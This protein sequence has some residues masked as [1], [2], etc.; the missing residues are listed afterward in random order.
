[1]ARQAG[2]SIATV[3]RVFNGAASVHPETRERI[4]R[5]ATS[6][7]YQPSPLG[8]NLVRGRSF[9]MGLLVPNLSFPLYGTIMHGIEDVLS[10]QGMSALLAS[11]HDDAE[12]ERQ[13]AGS[14]LRHAVDGGIIIN[15]QLGAQLPAQRLPGW[16]HVSPE[17]EEPPLRVELD[18][19]A[20]GAR[21]ATSVRQAARA[22]SARRASPPSC[23]SPGRATAA[24]RATTPR[25]ADSGPPPNCS[26]GRW[27]RC[28]WW[29]T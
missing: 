8:R 21:S 13:A 4:V 3:S 2:V 27:T 7:G 10:A 19:R 9:L 17:T 22:V 20:G 12:G 5:L 16:V 14:I 25:K 15:S 28:S 26:V 29:A 1:M 23:G 6:L 18:N 24:P 11:S